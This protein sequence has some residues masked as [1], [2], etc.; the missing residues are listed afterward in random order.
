MA[1]LARFVTRR[2]YVV[3]ALWVVGAFA[4]GGYGAGLADKTQDDFASFLPKDA[5]ST[6]VQALLKERFPGGETSSGLILY[7]RDGGPLTSADK[8]KIATD[9]AADAKRIHFVG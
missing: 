8:A 9:A 4:L 2:W 7:Q 6:E 1:A 5:E 3:I